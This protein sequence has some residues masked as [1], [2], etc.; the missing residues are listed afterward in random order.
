MQDDP[1]DWRH[2]IAKMSG[3]YQNA[4][5]TIAALTAKDSREG[6]FGF[7]L[8]AAFRSFLIPGPCRVVIPSHPSYPD[9]D[10]HLHSRGWVL[11]ERLLSPRTIQ[12]GR[13]G[14]SWE[15]HECQA[16]EQYPQGV[17]ATLYGAGVVKLKETFSDLARPDPRKGVSAE[18]VRLF[19]MSWHEL[20]MNYS[21]LNLTNNEDVLPAIAGIVDKIHL[22]TGFLYHYGLWHDIHHRELLLSELLWFSAHSYNSRRPNSVRYCSDKTGEVLMHEYERR[23]PSYSWAAVDGPKDFRITFFDRYIVGPTNFGTAHSWS[24]IMQLNTTPPTFFENTMRYHT[25]F[26]GG[27]LKTLPFEKTIEYRSEIRAMSSGNKETGALP[28]AYLVIKGPVRTVELRA[29]RDQDEKQ[30]QDGGHEWESPWSIGVPT[31]DSNGRIRD[32]EDPERDEMGTDRHRWFFPDT[33]IE[34]VIQDELVYCLTI[35]RWRRH[36]NDRSYVAGLVLRESSDLVRGALGEREGK[37]RRPLSR[38]GYFEHSW[39][40]EHENWKNDGEVKVVTIV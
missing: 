16:H 34:E 26:I 7:R 30:C 2:E 39:D 13:D 29:L 35:V 23:A 4:V 3:I 33:W 10:P 6:C 20:L 5:F 25:V 14:I 11:Q 15:C 31:P 1:A 37:I 36:G 21:V 24:A 38:I 27:D 40:T 22:D 28:A 12:F 32:E 19:Q 8:P 18:D 17:P 9:Y